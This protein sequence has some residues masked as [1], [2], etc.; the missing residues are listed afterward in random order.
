M[1]LFLRSSI[2]I[3]I[4]IAYRNVVCLPYISCNGTCFVHEIFRLDAIE[5][6][7][8]TIYHI[9]AIK[10]FPK[11]NF[12]SLYRGFGFILLPLLEFICLPKDLF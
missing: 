1:N 9:V 8:V 6:Y 12:Q 4:A 5:R 3:Y 2:I 10:R 7:I 11:V